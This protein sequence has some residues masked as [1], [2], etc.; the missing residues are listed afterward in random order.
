MIDPA[1]PSSQSAYQAES[2]YYGRTGEQLEQLE[3]D[4]FDPLIA[5]M[6][7]RGISL[8]DIN[9]YLYAKHAPERNRRMD[10][11]NHP[12]LDPGGRD[13]RGRGSGMSDDE[14]QAVLDR[15]TAAGKMADYEA[16]ERRIR[17]IIDNTR[18]GLVDSGLISQET[19]DAWAA[20]YEFYVPL[21]GFEEGTEDETHG[22]PRR[23]LRHPGARD[24]AGVRPIEQGRGPLPY[25]MQQAEMAIVRGEKNR[26]GNAWLRFVRSH[27]MPDR[28]SVDTPPT[29][30][31]I[32]KRTGL[33]TT[34]QDAFWHLKPDIFVTKIGGKPVLIQMKGKDGE[35]VVRALKNMGTSNLNTVLRFMHTLTTTMSRL[36]TQWNPN[37]VVPNFAR[38]VGE[39]FINLQAQDQATFV[40]RS[41]STCS[42]PSRA[43]STR[44]AART[45]APMAKP[46]ASSTRRA[47]ASAS[48]A[49]RI[50]TTSRRTSTSACAGWK[51]GRSTMSAPPAR[52]RPTAS[53][54]STAPS[55]TRP[56]LP[57]S[58]RRATSGCR[59]R[60]PRCSPAT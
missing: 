29:R 27:P 46:S 41:R 6:K 23:R 32:D 53:R 28:W 56:G 42:R 58:W 19:A 14:A 2:L 40:K 17:T 11:I 43:P 35:N 4:H 5:D 60:T 30:K 3:R 10:E 24:P 57:P 8:E 37:F 36:A 44:S 1:L 20:Q 21:R 9:E 7:A 15:I 48:S 18:N 49:S 54:S 13:L 50:T 47:A 16:V 38:D 33:V 22:G 34:V 25:I 31:A 51:A 12:E 55:R 26:V 39:A 45:A 59:R 52:P